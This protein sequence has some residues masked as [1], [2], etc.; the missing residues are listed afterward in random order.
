MAETEKR[1]KER[2]K[3]KNHVVRNV[4]G[5]VSSSRCI[6]RLAA[7]SAHLHVTSVDEEC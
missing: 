4:F 1:K 3:T 5:H 2:L 6:L 7:A